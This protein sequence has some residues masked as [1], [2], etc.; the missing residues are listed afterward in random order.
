MRRLATASNPPEIGPWYS[1]R[2]EWLAPTHDQI[3]YTEAVWHCLGRSIGQWW[4]LPER[5][6]SFARNRLADAVS[7]AME[8]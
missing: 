3:T 4:W 5:L 1:R 8:P 2:G 6:D 7:K